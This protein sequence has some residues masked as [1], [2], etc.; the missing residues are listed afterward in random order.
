MKAGPGRGK[1]TKNKGLSLAAME[2]LRPR[3]MAIIN[4]G[5]ASKSLRTR[6]KTVADFAEYVFPKQPRLIQHSGVDGKEILIRLDTK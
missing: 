4:E 3:F 2:G 5:L 6:L 1:G